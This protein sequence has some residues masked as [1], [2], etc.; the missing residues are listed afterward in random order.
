MIERRIFTDHDQIFCTNCETAIKVD[1]LNL[2]SLN[3]V[4]HFC[5]PGREAAW[6]IPQPQPAKMRR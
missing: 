4:E 2:F 3:K 1:K 5:A 6:E